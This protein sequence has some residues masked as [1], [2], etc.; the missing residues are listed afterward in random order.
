MVQ[1]DR[2]LRG[3]TI[4]VTRPREQAQET[5]KAIEER[6]GKPYLFPTIEIR[7]ATDLS[8]TKAFFRALASKKVD[9]VILMSVNGVRHLLSAAESIGVEDEIKKNL[10]DTVTVAVGPKTAN[11]LQKNGIHVDLIPEKYT[12]EGILQC[13]QQ[14][15]V[16]G[17]AIYIPRTSEAPPDL[18]EKLREMGNQ[19]KEVYVYQ[20]HVPT[21]RGVVGA[22]L[23]DLAD[24]KI[25]AIVFSSSLGV[26][27]F[28]KILKQYI[29]EE[30]LGKLL[31]Q[32]PV[33]VAIGP[34]TAKTLAEAD[35]K[36]DVIPKKSTLDEAL[37]ALVTYWNKG[38]TSA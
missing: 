8:S 18:A 26:K 11:E 34:T 21:D 4:V 5:V 6:G 24:E 7:G 1:E 35:I 15:H 13:L 3:R 28:F 14:L 25:D 19:V 22:F 36:V 32:K 33:I 27:N 30:K 31:E 29:P 38:R 2:P 9:Y 12:S 20:S 16:S 17:K 37:D 10:K 23:M